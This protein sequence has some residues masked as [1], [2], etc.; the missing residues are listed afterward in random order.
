[1]VQEDKEV[2]EIRGKYLLVLIAMCG[3]IAASIGITTNTAGVYITPVSEAFGVG[4]GA[5]SMT[6]TIANLVYAMAGY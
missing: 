4:K 3:V 5:V 2:K 1:M 6:L